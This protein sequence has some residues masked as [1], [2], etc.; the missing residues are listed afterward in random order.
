M[1]D[2]AGIF[3]DLFVKQCSLIDN[4]SQIPESLPS[5]T[6]SKLRRIEIPLE[7]I[8]QLINQ[9]DSKKAN[10]CDEISIRMLKLCAHECSIPLK[11]LYD[12]SLE[13]GNYPAL[14]KRGNVVPIHKK[15]DRQVKTNYRPIS[16][17]PI[18]GK[19][20]EK[21]I[22]DEVYKHLAENNLISTHQSGFRPGDSTIN[23]LLLITHEIYEA[24]ENH[25]ETRAVFLDISKAFDKVGMKV[26]YLNSNQMGLM[27]SFLL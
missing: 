25:Q 10:G 19:I 13:T 20:F 23:Q 11:M 15:G 21:I 8:V 9:L 27:D 3:N 18:C 6:Q 4:E 5:R 22:F 26:F 24:F 7:K 14:W 16:L 1:Q 17:L 2:K 12:M